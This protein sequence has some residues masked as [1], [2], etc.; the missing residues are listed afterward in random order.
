MWMNRQRERILIVC[1]ACMW[2]YL[3]NETRVRKIREK[4]KS[5]VW[6]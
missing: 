4:E 3:P 1:S 6:Y 2:A 5:G